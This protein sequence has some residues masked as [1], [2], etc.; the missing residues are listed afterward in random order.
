MPN[1]FFDTSA[2]GKHYHPEVGTAKVD[3]ALG[4]AGANH[5][6]SRLG[7]VEMLSVF[8]GKVRAGVITAT[9]FDALRRRFLTDVTHRIFHVVRM[10]GSHYQEAERLVRQHGATQRLRTLDAIQLAVA[11]DLRGLGLIDR[12]VCA[13]RNLLAVAALEGLLVMDPEQP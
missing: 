11:L 12:F 7:V 13:D 1:N 8:A 4:E 3:A 9:D 5:F 10:T 2:L 6:I